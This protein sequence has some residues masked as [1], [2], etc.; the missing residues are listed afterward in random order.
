[1]PSPEE[2]ARRNIE[3]LDS[4]KDWSSGDKTLS[5]GKARRVS[6]GSANQFQQFVTPDDGRKFTEL[7]NVQRLQSAQLDR[8]SRVCISTIQRWF[9]FWLNKRMPLG[10]VTPGDRQRFVR[11]QRSVW[12]GLGNALAS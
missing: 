6:A 2:L 12:N 5:E 8:V 11:V 7:Y 10:Q 9:F 4:L 1:M 3:R